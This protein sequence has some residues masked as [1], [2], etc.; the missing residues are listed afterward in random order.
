MPGRLKQGN[1]AHYAIVGRRFYQLPISR[2]QQYLCEVRILS[3]LEPV[4]AF[5]DGIPAGFPDLHMSPVNKTPSL[6]RRIFLQDTRE[7]RREFRIIVV[8]TF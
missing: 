1:P 5:H 3:K 2:V 4:C 7:V 6:S 8:P